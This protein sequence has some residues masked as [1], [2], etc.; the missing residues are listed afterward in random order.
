VIGKRWR[1]TYLTVHTV[2]SRHTEVRSIH[3]EEDV[4]GESGD[5]LTDQLLVGGTLD[6]R[7]FQG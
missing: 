5:S 6:R 2:L 3:V 1:I 4:G 7:T